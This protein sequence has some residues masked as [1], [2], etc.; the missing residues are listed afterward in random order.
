[1]PKKAK[2][3]KSLKKHEPAKI[4]SNFA[5]E[6]LRQYVAQLEQ[7]DLEK[8]QLSEHIADI[9][10]VAKSNGLDTKIIRQ[11][12]KIRK[13]AASQRQEQE[14]LLDLYMHA[15]GMLPLFE[16]TDTTSDAA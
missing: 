16:H 15:L 8:N 12:L 7:L 1:M 3:E 13:L 10:T 4:G 2:T 6:K 5:T 11:I 14:E 9:Y